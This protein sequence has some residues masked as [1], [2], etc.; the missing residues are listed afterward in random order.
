MKA[1]TRDSKL[2][3]LK[4][5]RMWR[6]FLRVMKQFLRIFLMCGR[7]E[8]FS[9][10]RTPRFLTNGE[11]GI[12]E[13][14]RLIELERV[15]QCETEFGVPISITS[16]LLSLSLRKLSESQFELML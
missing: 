9:S 1:C 7:K 4:N 12:C 10:N 14:P 6:R 5:E 11:N 3:R 13:L 2:G 15:L 8:R 16:D